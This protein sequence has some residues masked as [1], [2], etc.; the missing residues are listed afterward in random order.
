MEH[1]A[2]E[3]SEQIRINRMYSFFTDYHKDKYVFNGEFHDFWETAYVIS[4]SICVSANENVYNLNEGDIIFYEPL[5]MHKFYTTSKNTKLLIFSYDLEGNLAN[6]FRNKVFSLNN[7]QKN[8]IS[9]LLQHANA[10]AGDKDAPNFMPEHYIMEDWLYYVNRINEEPSFG[11]ELVLYIYQ[12]MFSLS[13]DGKT[14]KPSK[15]YENILFGNAVKFMTDNLFESISVEDV[16]KHL[17]VS[18]STIKRIFEKCA[19]M[20][21]HKYYLTLRINMATEMLENG[22]SVNEVS[23]KLGFSSPSYFTI[24]YTR[25]TKRPPSSVKF[26]KRKA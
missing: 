26:K 13:N 22:L 17:N 24:A 3:I 12:L 4:G 23:T 11:H 1:I 18:T 21:V 9:A 5:V 25:E 16:A 20:G 10:E 8:I 2:Y 7:K 15:T 6:Y 19:G 14:A